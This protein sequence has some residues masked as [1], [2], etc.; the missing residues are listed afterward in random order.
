MESE[1][2]IPEF[3]LTPSEKA[4]ACI[5]WIPDP[6]GSTLDKITFQPKGSDVFLYF[7]TKTFKVM[8]K[9]EVSLETLQMSK[10]P[11]GQILESLV[12]GL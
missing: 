10:K 8:L 11:Y 5:S 6:R 1:T 12:P 7:L 3:M 9:L 2:Q 4:A